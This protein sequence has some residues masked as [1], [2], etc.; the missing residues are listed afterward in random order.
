MDESLEIEIKKLAQDEM[1]KALKE[2]GN[3][4]FWPAIVK[5]NRQRLAFNQ[6]AL[7]SV[8]VFKD[9]SSAARAQGILLGI[10]DLQ[11]AVDTLNRPKVA[12]SGE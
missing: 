2:L 1:M 10:S 9:P 6:S 3:T 5:Y 8:D 11:N 4:H 7:N 12:E